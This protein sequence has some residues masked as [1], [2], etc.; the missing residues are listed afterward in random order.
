MCDTALLGKENNE[1]CESAGHTLEPD[2]G[3]LAQF[4]LSLYSNKIPADTSFIACLGKA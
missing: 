1:M 4:L 2:S 3:V